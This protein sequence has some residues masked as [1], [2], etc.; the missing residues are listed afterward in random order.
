MPYSGPNDA[1]LPS[2]V[3]ELPLQKRRQWIAVCNQCLADGGDDG[4]CIRRANGVV[5]MSKSNSEFIAIPTHHGSIADENASWE[6]PTLQDFTDESWENLSDAEKRRIANHFVWSDSGVIPE[7]FTDLGG[8]HHQASKSG[9]GPAVWR[10]VSSGRM[11]QASWFSNPGVRA[12]LA[13]HYAQFDKEVPWQGAKDFKSVELFQTGTWTDSK[14]RKRT[15]STQDLEDIVTAYNETKDDIHPPLKLGHS[16]SQ[17]ILDG[18]PAAGWIENLRRVGNKLVGDFKQVPDKLA[19]LIE[20]GAYRARSVELSPNF[21]VNDKKYN[22]FLTAVALLGGRLPAVSG[23]KDIVSLYEREGIEYENN[24]LVYFEAEETDDEIERLLEELQDKLNNAIKG[25]RGAP[26]IR[27]LQTALKNAISAS[28]KVSNEVDRDKLAK[29][30]ELKDDATDEEIEAA[31]KKLSHSSNDDDDKSELQN[32]VLD[33]EKQLATQDAERIVDEAIRKGRLLPKQRE[34]ALSYAQR[35]SDG[36]NKFIESQPEN[37]I[38]FGERGSSKDDKI[39]LAKYEP[40]QIE[41]DV[42]KQM[43]VYDEKWRTNLMRQK[44]A[45]EGVELP[46]DFGKDK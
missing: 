18:E 14:G 16:D 35:D 38:E 46:A 32:R 24:E 27:A 1:N 8:P 29:M 17:K 23:L 31:I 37:L 22:W 42:A 15:W 7:N 19:K 26:H 20:S 45:I 10:G 28:R 30:L 41:I 25:R 34:F 43:N 21:E 3:K 4:E 36:F 5:R 12:H 11:H 33:L 13:A 39:N 2:N 9:V 6:A 40:S 44:A